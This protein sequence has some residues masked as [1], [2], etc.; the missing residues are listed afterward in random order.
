MW[1]HPTRHAPHILS[2]NRHNYASTFK[3][4]Y[5]VRTPYISPS[6]TL[7]SLHS[8]TI[9]HLKTSLSDTEEFEPAAP[10]EK[11]RPLL[12]SRLFIIPIRSVRISFSLFCGP[13]P[14]Q[15]MPSLISPLSV[16]VHDQITFLYPHKNLHRPWLMIKPIPYRPSPLPLTN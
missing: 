7:T 14:Q 15:G 2:R 9:R 4:F 16:S 13:I 11:V 8:Q 3:A 10:S 6:R 12:S 5:A 1:S